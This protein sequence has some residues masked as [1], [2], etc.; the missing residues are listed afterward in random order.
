MYTLRE[1]IF[2]IIFRLTD[3]VRIR[4]NFHEFEHFTN[5][6]SIDYQTE[7]LGA[8]S[9]SS[10]RYVHVS[11]INLQLI[12]RLTDR[13]QVRIKFQI[14]SH[15][16]IFINLNITRIDLQLLFRSTDRAPGPNQFSDMFV[17][18]EV[19]FNYFPDPRIGRHT[20][21]MFQIFSHHTKDI[22]YSNTDVVYEITRRH[23]P[24]NRCC[25]SNYN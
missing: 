25:V 16:A 6:F 19:I 22:V 2:Q 1:L 13:Q 24:T 23:V 14:C 7:G 11:R 21:I 9:G 17:L 3:R 20:R 4:I 12:F 5:E 15:Y 8:G 10:F 18:R